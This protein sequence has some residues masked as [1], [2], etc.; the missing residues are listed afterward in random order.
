MRLSATFVNQVNQALEEKIGTTPV[1]WKDIVDHITGKGIA[2]SNWLHVRAVLQ[3]N[4]LFKRVPSIHVE[5]YR[6]A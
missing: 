1:T 4:K 2:V 6:R 3:S 5:Q